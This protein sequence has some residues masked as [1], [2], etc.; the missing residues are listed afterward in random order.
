MEGKP[1]LKL[2]EEKGWKILNENR[3]GHN[4]DELMYVEARGQSIIDYSVVNKMKFLS[5]K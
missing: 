3:T 4:K 5:S 1:L 2:I